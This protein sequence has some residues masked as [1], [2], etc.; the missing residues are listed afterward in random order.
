M[1][2]QVKSILLS[3]TFWL[4]VIQGVL[5]VIIVISS[6]IPGVGWVM[7]LKTVL[8]IILRFLT[9]KPVALKI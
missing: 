9:E 2:E 5:G 3:K 6:S 1:N 4:A 7:V 8:D